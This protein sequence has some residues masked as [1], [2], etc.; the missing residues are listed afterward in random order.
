[1]V[2]SGTRSA[3]WFGLAVA[4][5]LLSAAALYAT[6][7][8]RDA[9]TVAIFQR[10][11]HDFHGQREGVEARF[12]QRASATGR[13]RGLLWKN[14]DFADEVSFA[15]DRKS[16]QLIALVSI[17]IS[18]EAIEGGDMEDVEA[19]SNLRAGTAVFHFVEDRWDTHGRALFNLEP[20][21][22]LKHLQNEL[23]AVE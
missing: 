8:M 18:F 12:V 17:T 16:G 19:V 6:K 22:A 11:Q 5:I 14:V 2:R 1:M 23:E 15:K 10:A 21:E 3:V 9:K 20:L 7:C 4:L 13:P